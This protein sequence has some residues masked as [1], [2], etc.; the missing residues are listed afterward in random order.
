MFG[1]PT[2]VISVASVFLIVYVYIY[3]KCS[4]CVGVC[5]YVRLCVCACLIQYM[6]KQMCLEGPLDIPLPYVPHILLKGMILLT[7]IKLNLAG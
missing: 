6:Y 1:K 4:M 7:S 5:V 2:H 3:L